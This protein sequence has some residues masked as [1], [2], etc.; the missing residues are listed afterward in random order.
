MF[1]R[2]INLS[3]AL[4][5]RSVFLFGARQTGKSTYLKA[6]FPGAKY[7][8]L[9][10]AD[11]FRE[12][13]AAPERLRQSLSPS[14]KLVIVDEIQKLPSLLD[15][16]HLMIE[17]SKDRR[18]I[19]T[20]SSARKLKRGGVNL[21]A[22]RA[23]T[24]HLFPLTWLEAG[25]TRLSDKLLI[26]GLP[27]VLESQRPWEDL[28]EYVGTYLQE[29]IRAEALT[30]SIE[31]FSRFLAVASF[32]NGQQL[33]FTKIGADAQVP[34]RT[35]RE[36][37]SVLEDTMIGFQL[38]PYQKSLSRKPVATAKFY[39]FDLGVAHALQGI[40]QIPIGT[41]TFGRALEHLIATEL[42]AFLSYTRDQRSLCYWRTTSQIE[43]DFMIGDTIAIEVKGG[44]RISAADTK[45]LS[46]LSEDVTLQ[47]KIIV[48]TE[49]E[50]RKLDSGIEVMPVEMFMHRLWNNEL[51][52]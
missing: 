4:A 50:Y 7:V 34:P 23:L 27:S 25:A 41:P 36:F 32:A 22:A 38:P 24:Y 20:G 44:G 37:F 35:I 33:N 1:P 2:T 49:N 39:F 3:S 29:E 30:R 11:T 16:V 28:R 13:S 45:S 31:A 18:F 14:D 12:L 42:R 40:T 9:L 48:S 15:E 51:L 46:A 5:Q 19:L 47:R 8:D 21:L 6:T 26:G 10:A 52:S 17:Q 43:V